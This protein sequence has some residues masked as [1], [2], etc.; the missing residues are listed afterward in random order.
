MFLT[1]PVF[2]G[3]YTYTHKSSPNDA[4]WSNP[5][6]WSP[7]DHAPGP[8]DTATIGT[9]TS[10]FAV[11]VDSNIEVDQLTVISSTLQGPGPLVVDT[12]RIL[13]PPP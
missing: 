12:E 6:N 10:G 13:T 9:T 7:S 5:Q 4:T 2:A 8:G 3:D 1:I 11:T